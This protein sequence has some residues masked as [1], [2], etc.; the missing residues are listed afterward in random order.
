MTTFAVHNGSLYS[1]SRVIFQGQHFNLLDKIKP[2]PKPI[3]MAWALQGNRGADIIH[4][5][6]IL[7]NIIQAEALAKLLYTHANTESGNITEVL[8]TVQFSA[9]GLAL[10]NRE[11]SYT[12]GLV[13]ERQI[14]LINVGRQTDKGFSAEFSI[15]EPIKWDTKGAVEVF[16][17]HAE[18]F[19]NILTQGWSITQAYLKLSQIFPETGGVV[20]SWVMDKTNSEVPI[21]VRDTLFEELRSQSLVDDFLSEKHGAKT[22]HTLMRASKHRAV[23]ARID[24]L[25]ETCEELHVRLDMHNKGLLQPIKGEEIKFSDVSIGAEITKSENAS[26]EIAAV[27]Q[28][29]VRDTDRTIKYVEGVGYCGGGGAGSP[30]TFIGASGAAGGSYSAGGTGGA[31]IA[32]AGSGGQGVSGGVAGTNNIMPNGTFAA[33]TSSFHS[34]KTGSN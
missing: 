7:N 34:N 2:F 25:E 26:D 16:G 3:A 27:V 14:T 9:D 15:D 23:T 20:Q 31:V 11:N 13:G 30:T 19:S 4:G 5:Y 24:A 1:D 12:L 8:E 18:V 33:G 21:L 6:L 10:I 29:A 17:A 32:A 28:Q 22:T